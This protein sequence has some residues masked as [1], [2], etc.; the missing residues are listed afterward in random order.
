MADRLFALRLFVRVA[1]TG[2]FSRAGREFGVSQ[3]SASRTVAALEREIGVTLFTRTTRAVTLTDTG[4]DYLRRIEPMLAELAEADQAVR[5]DGELRG[6]LRIAMSSSFGVREVIPRLPEFTRRHPKLRVDI[7]VNDRHQDLVKAGA[8]VALRFG[9][10]RD[11][12]ATARPLGEQA[13]ILVASPAYL[14]ERGIPVAPAE[15]DGH[16][17]I[18]GPPGVSAAIWTFHRRRES[19]VQRVEG[20]FNISSNEGAVAAAVAG[21]GIASTASVGCH[22]ELAAGKLSRVLPEWRMDAVELHAVFPAGRA[23]KSSARAFVEYL[24]GALG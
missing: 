5:D 20:R 6:V 12:T 16:S 23:A 24:A 10:L 14:S 22:A 3:P 18:I 2:S 15:L 11:S 9:V 19:I 21:L 13:R 4:A 8:D 17:L 7:L 1:Q